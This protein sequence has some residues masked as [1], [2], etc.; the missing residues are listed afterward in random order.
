MSCE[1]GKG[2][3]GSLEGNMQYA[4]KGTNGCRHPSL[5]DVYCIQSACGGSPY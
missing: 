1:I 3:G 2:G 4:L 5:W